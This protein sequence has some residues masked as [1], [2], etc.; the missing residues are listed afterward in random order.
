[1]FHEQTAWLILSRGSDEGK[2]FKTWTMGANAMKL[3]HH[4]D[5]LEK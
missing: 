4:S 5:N 1:M 2:S 3:F